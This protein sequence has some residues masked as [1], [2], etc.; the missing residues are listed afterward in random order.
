M[1]EINTNNIINDGR[2]TRGKKIDFTK[3]N[4]EDLDDEDDE[5]DRDFEAKEEGKDVDME[6]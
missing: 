3:A 1:E 4:T 6:D 2:R 5:D